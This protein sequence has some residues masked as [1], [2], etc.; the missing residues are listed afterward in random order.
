MDAQR[1]TASA[2]TTS[3][4]DPKRR[5]HDSRD[6]FIRFLAGVLRELA[7]V[8]DTLAASVGP[9]VRA[10]PANAERTAAMQGLQLQ[11]T[12]KQRLERLAVAAETLTRDQRADLASTLKLDGLVTRLDAERPA[13]PAGPTPGEVELF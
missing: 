3:N 4:G 5:D 11:D 12:L 10:A 8:S 9:V 2:T 1:P 6:A 13:P 7:A